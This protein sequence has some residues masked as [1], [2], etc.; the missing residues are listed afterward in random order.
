MG[1]KK[2]NHRRHMIHGDGDD[3][4]TIII[5]ILSYRHC[6]TIQITDDNILLL[7]LW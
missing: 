4:G 3:S 6:N 7:I 1:K 5:I 2:G